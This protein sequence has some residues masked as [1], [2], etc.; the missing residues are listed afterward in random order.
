[1]GN[2][3]DILGAAIK[4]LTL[5]IISSIFETEVTPQQQRMNQIVAKLYAVTA[6][7]LLVLI[8]LALYLL[9]L[10][11]VA[12]DI[13]QNANINPIA[14]LGVLVLALAV[15]LGLLKAFQFIRAIELAKLYGLVEL[16]RVSVAYVFNGTTPTPWLIVALRSLL[17]I[18]IS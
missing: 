13:P 4:G 17:G 10:A 16:I 5:T 18:D 1:M 6:N 7:L 12:S 8:V 14:I 2:I 3:F 11:R 15:L 9:A